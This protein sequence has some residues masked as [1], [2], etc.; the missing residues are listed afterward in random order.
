MKK[1]KI[2][3]PT[4]KYRD[5]VVRIFV[6]NQKVLNFTGQRGR[7]PQIRSQWSATP[8]EVRE[9]EQIVHLRVAHTHVVSG[10]L[11][12][13]FSKK[14]LRFTFKSLRRKYSELLVRK[15]QTDFNL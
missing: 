6:P 14:Y 10:A 12:E 3:E 5:G 4:I 15:Q 11:N 7:P 2:N 13:M 9:L 1:M 8:D